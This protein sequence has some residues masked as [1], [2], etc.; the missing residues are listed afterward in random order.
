M[1]LATIIG[2]LS[3]CSFFPRRPALVGARV[4][5]AV[6]RAEQAGAAR[7]V[8]GAGR[9][10]LLLGHDVAVVRQVDRAGGTLAAP[11][12]AELIAALE[13][14]ITPESVDELMS[15]PDIDGCLVGGASLDPAKFARICNYKRS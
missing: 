15:K 9:G 1:F 12:D 6:R 7:G 11:S 10:P 2:K 13:G 8:G 3:E 4:L 5:A 14:M